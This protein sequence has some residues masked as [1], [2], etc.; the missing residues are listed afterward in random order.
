MAKTIQLKVKMSYNLE[1]KEC[2]FRYIVFIIYLDI[3]YI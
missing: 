2:F 1:W 3:M